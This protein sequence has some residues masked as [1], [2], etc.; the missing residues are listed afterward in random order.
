MRIVGRL[1]SIPPLSDFDQVLLLLSI[2]ICLGAC[3]I[4]IFC[5]LERVRVRWLDQRAARMRRSLR[6]PATGDGEKQAA[7]KQH[8]R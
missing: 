8:V 3:F 7:H 1:L 4:V 6:P 2:C 5:D